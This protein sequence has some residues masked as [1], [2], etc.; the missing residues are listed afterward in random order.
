MSCIRSYVW[1]DCESVRN[2]ARVAEN[3]G[4][5]FRERVYVYVCMCIKVRGSSQ[6]PSSIIHHPTVLRQGLSLNLTLLSSA[7]LVGNQTRIL[8]LVC[9]HMGIPSL[10]LYTSVLRHSFLFSPQLLKP[11]AG[12]LHHTP[13]PEPKLNLHIKHTPRHIFMRKAF[14]MKTLH[15]CGLDN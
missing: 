10:L 4:L 8:L 1:P 11:A 7:R 14:A 15:R 3:L 2:R 12:R 9:S 13:W 5:N 6:V